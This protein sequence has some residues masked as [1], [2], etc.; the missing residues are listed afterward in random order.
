V[1]GAVVAP[2]GLCGS[3]GHCQ[4]QYAR[5]RR[6]GGSVGNVSESAAIVGAREGGGRLGRGMRPVGPLACRGGL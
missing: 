5:L 6:G 1:V 3:N 4:P 2:V